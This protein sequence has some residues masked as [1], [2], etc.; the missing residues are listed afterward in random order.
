MGKGLTK[1]LK[2]N[3]LLWAFSAVKYSCFA[4]K[5]FSHA[6]KESVNM[7]ALGLHT[8]PKIKFNLDKVAHNIITA[9]K[10]NPKNHEDNDFEDLLQS[11]KS[12]E[13]AFEW[14]K[15]N[16]SLEKFERFREFRNER[17]EVIP[18]HVLKIKDKP[19]PSVI[20]NSEGPSSR[21]VSQ[22]NTEKTLDMGKA[23]EIDNIIE[24]SRK[25]IKK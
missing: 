25:S 12:F 14:A 19:T 22:V 21:I 20:V 24:S 3:K 16:L 4:L 11:A 1:V 13:Q 2:E 7:E 18:M 10:L 5:N 15:V 6:I 23:Q 8:L 17:L 9:V